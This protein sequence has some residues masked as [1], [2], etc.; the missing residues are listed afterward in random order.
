VQRAAGSAAASVVAAGAH[1]AGAGAGASPGGSAK[2]VGL[3][4][5]GGP[6]GKSGFASKVA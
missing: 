1:A 4:A 6:G 3:E 5:M 2:V